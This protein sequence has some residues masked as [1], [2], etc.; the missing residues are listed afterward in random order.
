MHA[1]DMPSCSVEDTRPVQKLLH[2]C[3]VALNSLETNL[4]NLD[5]RLRPILAAQTSDKIEVAEASLDRNSVADC[6]IENVLSDIIRRIRHSC[7]HIEHLH[8]T[9]RV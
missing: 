8:A 3:D 6:E 1:N 5:A 9:A 7:G 4:S 2:E